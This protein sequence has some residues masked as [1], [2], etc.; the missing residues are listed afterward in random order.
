MGSPPKA[1][2]IGP[3][4]IVLFVVN[5][6]VI[7][8]RLEVSGY[9]GGHPEVK[10]ELLFYHGRHPMC[11]TERHGVRKE[12]MYLD[13]LAITR[14]AEAHPMILHSKLLADRIEPGANL[15]TDLGIGVI[16]QAFHGVPDESAA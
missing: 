14:G 8:E 7:F 4:R 16:K 6:R 5:L 9:V 15:M 12:K 13:D 3:S 10:A 1:L 11:L 2:L